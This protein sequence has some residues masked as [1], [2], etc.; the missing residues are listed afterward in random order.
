L[1][2]AYVQARWKNEA[3]PP[4]E[5]T[6]RAEDVLNRSTPRF[7]SAALVSAEA[8]RQRRAASAEATSFVRRSILRFL[9]DA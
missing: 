5:E 4:P 9:W 7:A 8:S 6:S 1:F 3:H 2:A